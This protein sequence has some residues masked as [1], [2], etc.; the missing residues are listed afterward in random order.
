M[1][2]KKKDLGSLTFRESDFST[3]DSFFLQSNF[4]YGGGPPLI[5]V[6]ILLGQQKL[7]N[8]EMQFLNY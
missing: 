8:I 6:Y 2:C 5:C 1:L 7:E 4:S 3:N